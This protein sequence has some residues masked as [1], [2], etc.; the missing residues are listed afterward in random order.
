MHKK[1]SF[2]LLFFTVVFIT[3]LSHASAIQR[4]RN[5]WVLTYYCRMQS[6]QSI[7]NDDGSPERDY[8]FSILAVPRLC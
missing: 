2:Q 5:L 3:Q 8:V 1:E 6:Y 7:V 4:V